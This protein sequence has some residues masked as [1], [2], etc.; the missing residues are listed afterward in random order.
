MKKG[1]RQETRKTNTKYTEM[2][3]KNKIAFT[4]EWQRQDFKDE[5][6]FPRIDSLYLQSRETVEFLIFL[7]ETPT[8]RTR[9]VLTRT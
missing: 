1:E 2:C 5:I 7:G 9:D 4:H 3:A 6:A 8:S